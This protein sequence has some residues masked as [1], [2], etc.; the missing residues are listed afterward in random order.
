MIEQFKKMIGK[1][2]KNVS[3]SPYGRW[4]NGTLLAAE[5]GKIKMS[6]K[7][8]EEFA[9]PAGIAHGG[10]LAGIIDEV[11]G[12]TTHTLGRDGFFVAVNLNVDFLRAAKTGDEIT[13]ETEVVRAG[14]T[15]AH[16]ECQIFDKEGKLL[17][18]AS[19]NLLKTVIK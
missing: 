1:E 18:K 6:Y 17:A 11:I 8:R 16:V 3:P 15:I 5:E 10:V 14:K 7:V 19:S 9:N 4:L 2:A 13:I 12:M